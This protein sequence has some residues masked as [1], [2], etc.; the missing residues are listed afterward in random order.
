MLS[1][2]RP[3]STSVPLRFRLAKAC[4][5]AN[6]V[7]ANTIAASAPPIAWIS[8]AG[9][10][11]VGVDGVGGTEML[12]DSSLDFENVD[13]GDG[14]AGDLRVLHR[15][16]A[17]SADPEH[18]DEVRRACARHFDRLVGGDAGA[19]QRRRIEWVDP[20]RYEADERGVGD[21]VLGERR[22]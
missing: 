20:R 7:A 2:G 5:Q 9:S 15:Q 10:W 1:F 14:R 21:D 8:V 18:R 17:E 4:S 6:G 11:V 22:R 3:T 12:G 19:R 13:R 16:V